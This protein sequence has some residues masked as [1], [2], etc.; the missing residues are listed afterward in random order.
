M[1]WDQTCNVYACYNCA[2]NLENGTKVFAK[3][4]R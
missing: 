4:N 2:E 1:D 3:F